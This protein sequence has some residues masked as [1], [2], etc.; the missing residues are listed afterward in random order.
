[1]QESYIVVKTSV[2]RNEKHAY[3]QTSHV[4]FQMIDDNWFLTAPHSKGE[5]VEHCS[6]NCVCRGLFEGNC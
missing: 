3:Y 1:M 6:S 5:K 4:M 2:Q